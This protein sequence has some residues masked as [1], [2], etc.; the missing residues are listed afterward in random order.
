MPIKNMIVKST[1]KKNLGKNIKTDVY[2][3][4]ENNELVGVAVGHFAP[5]TGK[6]GHARMLENAKKAGIKKFIIVIPKTTK[7]L[8]DNRNMF[9]DEQKK[10]IIE[11][12]C[13]DLGIDL[14]DVTISDTSFSAAIINNLAKKYQQYRLVLLCG[15]DR[16]DDYLRFGRPF[17]IDNKSTLDKNDSE[18]RRFEIYPCDSRGKKN[19]SGTQVREFIKNNDRE[20]FLDATGYSK[21]LWN[22]VRKFAINNGVIDIDEGKTFYDVLSNYNIISEEVQATK[23]EGI[24][25][26]YNPGNSQELSS[27]DFIDIVKWIKSQG[28]KLDD[29]KNVSYSEKSDGCA[30]RFGLNESNKFFIEQ[31]YSGPVYDGDFFREKSLK[32][33]G[34]VNRMGKAWKD[35]FNEM[36]A[37]KSI[38]NILK[39]YNTKNG[40][41]VIGEVYINEIGFEGKIPDTLRFVG[42]EYYKS[43]LGTCCTII[44]FNVV[45]GNGE[46]IKNSDNIRKEFIKS[47]TKKII[48]DDPNY[49]NKF[50]SIDFKKEIS[51]LENT[52][53][54][55]QK[56]YGQSLEEILDSKSKKK[57]DIDK[58]N[59]IK[60]AI[61]KIQEKFDKKIKALFKNTDG[62]WGPYREG[63]VLKLAN[64]VMLKI[65]SDEFKKFKANH[66]DDTM[67][68]WL[69]EPAE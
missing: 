9:T 20:K 59:A 38:Q 11:K 7:S 63:I 28:G 31:S 24:K 22:I 48:F 53:K 42:M 16:Y 66:N 33:F 29:S 26:L 36:K 37:D 35:L 44:I 49:P 5:F 43:K 8:D 46:K 10:Y 30:L 40:I 39:K 4:K 62:K 1:S 68:N 19:V 54:N 69:R 27:K 2:Y 32:K 21:K 50:G 60:T 41:K 25:H 64:D 12:G 15:P 47:S 55:L 34:F 61:E 67:S 13:E 58:K 3:W 45:D 51:E 23:R 17:N 6:F 14:L 52:V 18:F 57:D 56:E 65:T